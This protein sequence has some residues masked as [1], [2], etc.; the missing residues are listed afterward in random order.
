MIIGTKNFDLP[1]MNGWRLIYRP[2][3][4]FFVDI[5]HHLSIA[6]RFTLGRARQGRSGNR[7]IYPRSLILLFFLVNRYGNANNTFFR[8]NYFFFPRSAKITQVVY[9]MS[10]RRGIFRPKY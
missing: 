6:R 2:S 4:Y 5:F 1:R 8:V 7:E 3:D 9:E 10:R